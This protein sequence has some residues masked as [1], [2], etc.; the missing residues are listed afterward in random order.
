MDPDQG[1]KE[2]FTDLEIC[3]LNYFFCG[4]PGFKSSWNETDK[5]AFRV[6]RFG[7]GVWFTDPGPALFLIGFKM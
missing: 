4:S 5:T 2:I 7:I 3:L 1:P 6:H